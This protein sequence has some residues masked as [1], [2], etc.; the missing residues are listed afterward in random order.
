LSGSAE[1]T[2]YHA[3]RD[4]EGGW[5]TQVAMDESWY[6][7]A[8]DM[9]VGL[10]PRL[11]YD[12]R[13]LP[14]VISGAHAWQDSTTTFEEQLMIGDD[15]LT[16]RR[17]GTTLN[18]ITDNQ[19]STTLLPFI[20]D[21][22]I[23]PDFGWVYSAPFGR[24]VR[25]V[26]FQPDA[27]TITA[28]IRLS[29]FSE[30][31]TDDAIAPHAGRDDLTHQNL[32]GSIFVG[33][34]L[35]FNEC[36]GPHLWGETVLAAGG[37]PESLAPSRSS[38]ENCRLERRAPIRRL[39]LD[40]E[41]EA[42]TTEGL[43]GGPL[44][45]D[46]DDLRAIL[47]RHH[48]RIVYA[49]GYRPYEVG[50]GPYRQLVVVAGGQE[51]DRA[52]YAPWPQSDV[53]RIVASEPADGARDV[54]TDVTVRVRVAGLTGGRH[55]ISLSAFDLVDGQPVAHAH[56]VPAAD[57]PDVVELALAG[58]APG[59]PHRVALYDRPAGESV[60][61]Q[62]H[63]WQYV[64]EARPVFTFT[65]AGELPA[66]SVS[67]DLRGAPLGFFC[68]FCE[69]SP[70]RRLA[71]DPQ[72]QASDLPRFGVDAFDGIGDAIDQVRVLTDQYRL[73]DADGTLVPG[74]RFYY[75]EGEP[76]ALRLQWFGPLAPDTEYRIELPEGFRT[77]HGRRPAPEQRVFRFRTA[78]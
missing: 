60:E 51:V 64:D 76:A 75:A 28:G 27:T 33:G 54:P 63:E 66:G 78:P 55:R 48:A 30:M 52:H 74:H 21:V 77:V 29:S 24:R 31:R 20:G 34:K 25:A 62:L 36:K 9:R 5:R 22:A 19:A 44:E 45:P 57:E 73:T 69:P 15:G 41:I 56:M 67:P 39:R 50:V 46:L 7:T 16:G 26:A 12:H 1:V 32:D 40:P 38:A 59:T 2:L 71:P 49:H 37:L 58:L 23:D 53:L 14:V 18:P 35:W 4:P 6:E 65:T 68:D 61:R 47:V 3:V 43:H 11:A 17:G 42:I 10:L 8:G 13:D 72:E 70:T